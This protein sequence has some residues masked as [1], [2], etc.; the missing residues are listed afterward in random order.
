MAKLTRKDIP[1]AVKKFLKDPSSFD[2][3]EDS[4]F[5]SLAKQLKSKS[6]LSDRQVEITQK[7]IESLKTA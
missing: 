5:Q 2:K 1:D 4:Y 7:K 3:K 6:W